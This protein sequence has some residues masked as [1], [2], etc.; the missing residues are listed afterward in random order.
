MSVSASILL[1]FALTVFGVLLVSFSIYQV[2]TPETNV[3]KIHKSQDRLQLP[4]PQGA[5]E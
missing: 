4:C 5:N 2:T 1:M 3:T